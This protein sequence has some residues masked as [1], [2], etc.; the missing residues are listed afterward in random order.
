[1]AAT[2][3]RSRS[4]HR[5]AA[6]TF[7]SNISLDGSYKDT[8]LALLPRNGAIA[9]PPFAR[10]DYILEE[11]DGND[12]CFSESENVPLKTKGHVKKKTHKIANDDDS[13][14]SDSD[15][16]ATPLKSNLDANASKRFYRDR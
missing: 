6:V 4:R 3:K 16:V 7:L 5:I 9:K 2:L 8:K 1:M 13:A 11:S 15:T 14:N 12:E 10:N